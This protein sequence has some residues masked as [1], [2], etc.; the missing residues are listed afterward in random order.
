[1]LHTPTNTI[2]AAPTAV[3][4]E[5]E[6]KIMSVLPGQLS[7]WLRYEAASDY[8]VKEIFRTWRSGVQVDQILFTLRGIQRKATR[9]VYGGEHPQA[10][11]V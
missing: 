5:I 8:C 2:G 11:F 1:M 9:S 7:D 3:P 4:Q 10:S 6:D